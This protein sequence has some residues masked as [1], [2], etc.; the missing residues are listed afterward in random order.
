MTTIT[1]IEDTA[2]EPKRPSRLDRLRDWYEESWIGLPG[3]VALW[4][5][6][7]WSSVMVGDTVRLWLTVGR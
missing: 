1:W 6:V 2:A 7:G 4:A 3:F 5:A